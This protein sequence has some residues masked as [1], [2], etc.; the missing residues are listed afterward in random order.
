VK[1]SP[2]SE[3]I[4]CQKRLQE[5]KEELES[6]KSHEQ[7]E[8]QLKRKEIRQ[9][10]N[11]LEEWTNLPKHYMETA[12]KVYLRSLIEEYRFKIFR[13]YIKYP[14]MKPHIPTL[15]ALNNNRSLNFCRKHWDIR[16]FIDPMLR[17]L[18]DQNIAEKDDQMLIDFSSQADNENNYDKPHSRFSDE[19]HRATKFEITD[20][21]NKNYLPM[22]LDETNLYREMFYYVYGHY[23]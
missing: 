10:K 18:L 4:H 7:N 23:P 2:N 11:E 17:L 15:K 14:T 1:V 19:I 20:A 8:L 21:I 9:L 12:E 22:S 13:K 16:S 6:T 5:L 3:L